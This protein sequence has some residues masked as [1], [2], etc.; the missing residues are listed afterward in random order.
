MPIRYVEA[1]ELVVHHAY[2]ISMEDLIR[3]CISKSH[4]MPMLYWCNGIAFY[5][6]PLLPIMNPDVEKDFLKGVD[7]WAEVYYS[8]MKD[9]RDVIELDDGEFKG[10]KIRII[11]ASGFMPHK[12][13][14]SWAN[15][16]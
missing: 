5:Y 8:D 3:T 15:S 7:H 10:A 6:E 16:Q 2:K 14:A 9:Y 1:T 13:F 12:D 11:D 4:S